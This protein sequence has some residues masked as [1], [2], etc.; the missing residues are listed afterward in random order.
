MATYAVYRERASLTTPQLLE[1]R[2][3]VYL[4]EVTVLLD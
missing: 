1:V 4:E 2:G 3:R